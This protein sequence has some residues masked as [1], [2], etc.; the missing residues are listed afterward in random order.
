VAEIEIPYKPRSWAKPFHETFKRFIALVLHRR[1]GK[2]TGIINHLQRSATD[3]ERERNRLKFLAPQLTNEQLEELLR[4]RMYGHILPTYKQAKYVAWDMLKYFAAPIPDI[5]INESE[6]TIR[7]PGG[8]KLGLFG[9]DNPDS[10]RGIPF[11]GL[12]FDEYSQHPP[13]IF[14]EVLSK[15][16]ADHLGYAIFAGTIIG[17]NQLYKTHEIAAANPDDWFALWQDVDKSLAT[18]EGATIEL[19]KIAIEDDRKLVAQG[20]MTQEE[21]DQEWYLSPT[22][23]IKGAIY[24][25]QLSLMR[26]QGRIKLVPYDPALKVHIVLDLGVGQAFGAGFYQRVFGEMR[27]I[28]YWQGTESD[29]IPQ[30]V[31]AF[32]NKPYIYGKLFLPHDAEANSIDTGQTRVQTF[33]DLWPNIEIVIVPK[34]SVDDGIAKG[35]AMFTR[36]WVDEKNCAAWLDAIAQYR[37]AHDDK[38][39]MFKETPL[40]DWTSH[41]ADVHRYASVMEDEMT[42]EDSNQTHIIQENQRERLEAQ[43]DHGL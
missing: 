25:Q 6:L 10:L 23:A 5:K 9:A 26:Q 15:S 35:R 40:H 2:T 4:N 24:G 21:F 37:L 30:A 34:L 20:M 18:E 1:A 39:G 43:R 12:G 22:A 33:K 3:D 42:N 28:D 16:L 32:Q 36:L 7:Y 13:N 17:K 19:L 29:G 41:P 31:K 27:M 11:W 14:S 38:K 8:H